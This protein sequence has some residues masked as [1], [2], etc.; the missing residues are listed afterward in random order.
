LVGG[1]FK[2]LAAA[3]GQIRGK[4]AR[5]HLSGQVSVSD[6]NRV[7]QVVMKTAE[8]RLNDPK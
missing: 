6:H 1:R 4:N 2:K 8:L 3:D 5:H 7:F